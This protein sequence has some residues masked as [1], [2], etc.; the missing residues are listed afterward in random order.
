MILFFIFQIF[1]ISTEINEKLKMLDLFYKK[2]AYTTNFCTVKNKK[3]I[4]RNQIPKDYIADKYG[5]LNSALIGILR[6]RKSVVLGYILNPEKS[7]ILFVRLKAKINRIVVYKNE[8]QF[9][10]MNIKMILG[11]YQGAIDNRGRECFFVFT[12]CSIYLKPLFEIINKIEILKDNIFI[13]SDYP[14]VEFTKAIDAVLKTEIV[15]KHALEQYDESEIYDYEWLQM[16]QKTVEQIKRIRQHLSYFVK[17]IQTREIYYGMHPM[18]FK[19]FSDYD[20]NKSDV[21]KKL[22][23][24]NL[25]GL[26][27]ENDKYKIIRNEKFLDVAE[28]MTVYF[29]IGYEKQIINMIQFSH[30]NENP[31]PEKHVEIFNSMQE[32][33]TKSLDIF[34]IMPKYFRKVIGIKKVNYKNKKLL[35]C[36]HYICRLKHILH[37]LE[38]FYT[39]CFYNYY[40]K[41]SSLSDLKFLKNTY[42]CVEVILQSLEKE[43]KDFS[44]DSNSESHPSKYLNYAQAIIP[45]IKECLGDIGF[46]IKRINDTEAV[47]KE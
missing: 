28:I 26:F 44:V 17:K 30:L 10:I 8:I 16:F 18:S 31:I 20:E 39:P 47:N 14:E 35:P 27:K 23:A 33:L 37:F 5:S 45:K 32:I 42:F 24:K 12:Y 4:F 46:Q 15:I 22:F 29:I 11:K 41:Y 3:K 43:L 2:A 6:H 7:R 40:Y 34:Q 19:T 21:F 25:P 1:P 38:G 13:G 9:Y 36:A